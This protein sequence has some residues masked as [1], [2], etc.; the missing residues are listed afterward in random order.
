MHKIK[1]IL[2]FISSMILMATIGACTDYD[3]PDSIAEDA[4]K[5]SISASLSR[6]VL[7]I[8]IDG[9]RASVVEQAVGQG[10]MPNL[11][12]M[13]EHSKYSWSGLSDTRESANASTSVTEEDPVTWASMLTGVNSNLHKIDDYSYTPN[14]SLTPGSVG[15]KVTYFPTMVQYLGSKAPEVSVAVV[16]PW[17]NLNRYLGDAHSVNT[18]TSDNETFETSK[19]LISNDDFRFFIVSFKNVLE[20]GKAGG[21]SISNNEYVAKLSQTDEYIG[22]LLEAIESRENANLEDWLIVV[23]SNTGGNEAGNFTGLSDAE[24]DVFG[25]FYFNHYTPHEMKGETLSAILFNNHGTF[26]GIVPDSTAQYSLNQ[27]TVSLEFTFQNMPK[28]DGKYDSPW[29]KILGKNVYGVFRQYDPCQTIIRINTDSYGGTK[30]QRGEVSANDMLWHHFFYGFAVADKDTRSQLL[31]YDGISKGTTYVEGSN[32]ILPIDSTRMTIGEGRV[33]TDY[34]VSTVRIWKAIL[35]DIEITRNA[36][37]GASINPSHPNYT[38]L[39][40]E[41]ELAEEHYISYEDSVYVKISPTDKQ[42][43][44]TAVVGHIKNNIPGFPD[45]YFT[46]TPTF[47]KTANTLPVFLN[48]GNLMMEN[49]MIAPQILYWFCGLEGVDSKLCGYPFLKNY[50]IEEQWRDSEITE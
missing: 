28:T 34:R 22:R 30:F 17:Q 35:S 41:W 18:T 44:K 1:Y 20:A 37:N 19:K 4:V 48:S 2:Y 50:A 12:R 15:D 9:G 40:G 32:V 24:R 16:T 39:I 31:T 49:T 33:G 23:S 13:L 25:V 21:F 27:N 11:K 7:W 45:M 29:A 42:P 14:F 43:T 10:L 6:R 26:F 3:T 5:D 38:E 8:N 46:Q 47:V 36:E